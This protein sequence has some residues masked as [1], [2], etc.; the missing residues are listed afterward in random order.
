MSVNVFRPNCYEFEMLWSSFYILNFQ[1]FFLG[2]CSI[3]NVFFLL[4]LGH[5]PRQPFFIGL[6]G[7]VGTVP[8][9]VVLGVALR[10]PW[11]FT[12]A[13]SCYFCSFGVLPPLALNTSLILLSHTTPIMLCATWYW[14]GLKLNC[15]SEAGWT[16]GWSS[17][18]WLLAAPGN[19]TVNMGGAGWSEGVVSNVGLGTGL[20]VGT[21]LCGARTGVPF[22]A[23]F[24]GSLNWFCC[25]T[26]GTVSLMGFTSG[27]GRG[28]ENTCHWIWLLIVPVRYM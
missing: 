9:A 15:Y 6:I 26:P 2:F 17:W 23:L 12:L 20:G 24:A 16:R 7:T 5:H 4:P 18:V 14:F 21:C 10:I 19:I 27:E 3:K 28:S 1:S 11:F 13:A 25:S 8:A 22:P